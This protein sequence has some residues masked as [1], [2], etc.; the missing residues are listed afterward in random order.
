M[1]IYDETLDPDEKKDFT[2]D[3]VNQMAANETLAS[4]AVSFVDAAGTSQPIAA[5]IVSPIT[6][7]WLTGGNHGQRCIF[8]VR[9]TTSDGRTLEDSF[10]VNVVDT[11]IIEEDATPTELE[12]LRAYKEKLLDARDQAADGGS[13]AEVWNGRYGTRM[14]YN[15]MTYDEIV[16]ALLQVD[17]DIAALERVD[18]GGSR[19]SPIGIVWN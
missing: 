11:S 2:Q 7:V 13:V 4:V 10:A 12:R 3:W 16:K 18:S 17:R 8:V 19:R 9:V 1:F 14:K 15:A 5:G 6:R